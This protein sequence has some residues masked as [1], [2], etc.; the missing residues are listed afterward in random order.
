[1]KKTII[2]ATLG[3]IIIAALTAC[4]GS[5][6]AAPETT[7]TTETEK[8]A[9]TT[10][11]AEETEEEKTEAEDNGGSEEPI[12]VTLGVCGSMTEDVWANAIDI[13]AD[14]G[15]DL[16]IVE[17]SD[18][19]LPN[20]A[21]ASGEID[22]NQF[23]HQAFFN[24]EVAAHGYELSPVGHS[25][26]IPLNLYS[27]KVKSPDEIKD[28]AVVAIPN[29]VTNG[30]R[31]LK[32]LEAAGLIKLKDDIPLSPTVDDIE[33]YLVDITIEE[34]QGSV[35]PAALQDIDAAVIN[36]NYVVDF[37][38]KTDDAIFKDVS[39]SDE[40]YW[41]LIVVRT[42]DTKD[43]AKLDVFE[44]IVEAYQTEGTIDLYNELFGGYHVPVG[45]DR[46]LIAQYR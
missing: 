11:A 42:E 43:P 10:T 39:L 19:S 15:I 22:I 7:T 34:L 18:Y 37:G 20:N 35:I 1:M 14:E 2:T 29:D 8:P 3:I 16:E 26:I 36:G 41:G 31:A 25:Y 32:V 4:G 38:M 30:G 24:D 44:K 23:Q 28:G 17:F 12:K 45:W 9:A 33:E 40:N 46:D 5:Q 21:L 6:S 27:L 13:L